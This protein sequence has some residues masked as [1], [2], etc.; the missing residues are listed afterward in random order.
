L[1]GYKA[2]IWFLNGASNETW[3]RKLLAP[4]GS[5]VIPYNW[6]E[7]YQARIG[8]LLFVGPNAGFAAIERR[9]AGGAAWQ[10]PLVFATPESGTLGFGVSTS[11]LGARV[12]VGTTRWPYAAWC[13]EAA[14]YIRPA[15]GEIYG[16][17]MGLENQ[18]RTRACD[19]LARA[20][21]DPSFLARYPSAAATVTDLRPNDERGMLQRPE[22]RFE[23]EEFYN[24]NVTVR[25]VSISPR[26]CQQVMFRLRARRDEGFVTN[27]ATN[28]Y[29]LGRVV[30]RLDGAPVAVVSTVY[31]DTKPLV[32]SEDFLWG[33]HPLAFRTDD[34]RRA[35]GWML[36]E[37]WQIPVR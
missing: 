21:V 18:L 14:D 28:C 35:L 37:R 34:V 33:F 32:G 4:A 7:V 15:P 24:T 25:P 10:L 16:E 27:P 12:T 5:G 31:A 36:G 19:G 8:N 22:F 9:S 30:S 2:V 13:I 23:R 17:E 6:L 3:F 26:P 20:L 29:P 1:T 11:P